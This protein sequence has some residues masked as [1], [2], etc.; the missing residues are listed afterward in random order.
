VKK[1]LALLS[2]CFAVNWYL[3]GLLEES[4]VRSADNEP[5]GFKGKDLAG[6]SDSNRILQE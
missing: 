4:G 3:T 6:H 1:G 5:R 2:L